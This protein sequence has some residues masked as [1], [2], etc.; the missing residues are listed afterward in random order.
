[1][2]KKHLSLLTFTLF[3]LVVFICT[4]YYTF[5]LSRQKLTNSGP[6]IT[7]TIILNTPTISDLN[8]PVTVSWQ[9]D[10][11]T[12][13]RIT[14]TTIYYDT[15]ATPSALSTNDSPLAVGYEHSLNDYQTGDWQ[16]PQTFTARIFPPKDASAIFLRA[17]ALIE[18]N[19]YWTPE[20]KIMFK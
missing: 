6:T 3:V 8:A 19:H 12:P 4:S 9:I 13:R 7:P 17:Y 18:N 15:S 5:T 1:M 10:S 16:S 2:L 14:S 11:P 20:V